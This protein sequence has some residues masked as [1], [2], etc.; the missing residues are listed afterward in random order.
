MK[1]LLALILCVAMVLSLAPAAF[2]SP[3]SGTTGDGSAQ[4]YPTKPGQQPKYQSVI[5]AKKAIDD[6]NKDM[7]AMYYAIAADETVFGA[8]KGIFDFTDSLAKD[9]IKVESLELPGGGKI[10]QDTM[11][12]NVRKAL[13]NMIANEVENYVNERYGSFT[14]KV[15]VV[16]GTTR[17]WVP[18]NPNI[19]WVGN[20]EDVPV[21][22]TRTYIKPDKYMDVFAKGLSNALSS[23]KAQKNIEAMIYGLAA[24]NLQK[25]VNDRADDLY[26]DIVDWDHWDEFAAA[27]GG[28]TKPEDIYASAWMPT[29]DSILVP[30]AGGGVAVDTSSALTALTTGSFP[31]PN[32]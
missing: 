29:V 9:L 26:D 18:T 14:K 3:I 20:W 24:I 2:A 31:V 32:P 7:K 10:Y 19:P 11:Q 17:Q 12:E 25:D 15:D 21:V 8:A 27:W 5:N 6:L 28:L 30:T 13:N 16:T 22:E 1:K 23:S 4:S